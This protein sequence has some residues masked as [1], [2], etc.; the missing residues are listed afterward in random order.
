MNE[1]V[2][3]FLENYVNP[4]P[5]T[6]EF[7]YVNGFHI[8]Q[9]KA[10]FKS[11]RASASKTWAEV[12]LG[13]KTL[14]FLLQVSLAAKT[15]AGGMNI[16]C[17]GLSE[18]SIQRITTT[19]F[20]S[21]V[22][23]SVQ[24]PPPQPSPFLRSCSGSR[25]G[26]GWRDSSWSSLVTASL[27][28]LGAEPGAPATS[29]LPGLGSAPVCGCNVARVTERPVDENKD[30]NGLRTHGNARC[31]ITNDPYKELSGNTDVNK[32]DLVWNSA[33][34]FIIFQLYYVAMERIGL[35]VLELSVFSQF[36]GM[37]CEDVPMKMSFGLC[38][39]QR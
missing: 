30:S 27:W 36:T 26:A 16:S 10:A 22:N 25:L 3:K 34:G 37:N 32:D 12:I 4:V 20:N 18:R 19:K 15:E 29:M 39:Y 13:A 5:W 31:A 11:R 17:E 38:T 21:K 33:W 24:G 28:G 14:S 2:R 1:R 6:W 23:Q 35:F 9:P 7:S 8:H